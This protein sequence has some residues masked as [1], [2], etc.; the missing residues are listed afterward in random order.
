MGLLIPTSDQAGSQASI[1]S[2][3]VET[4]Y[5]F[6]YNMRDLRF[7][8]Q[9]A[10]SFSVEL[11]SRELGPL[12]LHLEQSTVPSLS[13]RNQQDTLSRSW[14]S[15][16]N[17]SLPEICRVLSRLSNAWF[18]CFL[19][20]LTLITIWLTC[21]WRREILRPLCQNSTRR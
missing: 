17:C 2:T 14:S 20:H 7:E 4:P 15:V 18:D 16:T 13:L 8:T 11:D 21:F 1:E 3:Q 5:Q 12:A 19:I 6:V 9:G 10:Y